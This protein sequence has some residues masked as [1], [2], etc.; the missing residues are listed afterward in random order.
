M[1]FL[2]SF[3]VLY[4]LD[5]F[6]YVLEAVKM[7]QWLIT[8][9]AGGIGGGIQTMS[10]FIPPIGFMFLCL[11]ILEDSGY[12]SRA[13]FVMDRFMKLYRPA[14]KIFCSTACGFRM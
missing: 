14:R 1:I 10:T 5:G 3:L 7:P 12:M 9:L 13:A 8:F 11:A 4:L 6:T 2:I